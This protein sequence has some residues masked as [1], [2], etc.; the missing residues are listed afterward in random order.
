MNVLDADDEPLSYGGKK[1]VV[2][3]I[4]F[5][6]ISHTILERHCAVCSFPRF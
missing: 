3:V 4:L 1:M 6:L 2:G 5:Q